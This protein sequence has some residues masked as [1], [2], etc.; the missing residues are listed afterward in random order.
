VT[1]SQCRFPAFLA[2][3]SLPIVFLACNAVVGTENI[4]YREATAASGDG[5]SADKAKPSADGDAATSSLSPDAAMGDDGFVDKYDGF[6]DKFD[7]YVDPDTGK[8]F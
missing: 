2:G 6:V 4:T 5:G 7:G 8:P 3:V 1:R